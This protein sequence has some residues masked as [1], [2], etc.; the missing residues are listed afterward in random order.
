MRAKKIEVPPGEEERVKGGGGGRLR[1]MK[2][3]S[4]RSTQK[5]KKAYYIACTQRSTPNRIDEEGNHE[6]M[7]TFNVFDDAIAIPPFE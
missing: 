5:R 1:T 2:V 3:G 4:I 7:R 6:E